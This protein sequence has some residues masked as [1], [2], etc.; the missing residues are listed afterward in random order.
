MIR[1]AANWRV[2]GD[3][4]LVTPP[5]PNSSNPLTTRDGRIPHLS[6]GGSYGGNQK[7]CMS[8]E[9]RSRRWREEFYLRPPG[10]LCAE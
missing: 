5:R 7:A 3:V 6:G 9:V 1:P 2:V 10:C 8:K 4:G